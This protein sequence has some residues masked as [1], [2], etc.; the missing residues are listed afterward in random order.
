MDYRNDSRICL[1]E[2]GHARKIQASIAIPDFS[3]AIACV[4]EHFVLSEYESG[5]AVKNRLNGSISISYSIPES[6]I[7]ATILFSKPESC[8]KSLCNCSERSEVVC[9]AEL[10][11]EISE[12]SMENYCHRKVIKAGTI[13]VDERKI[14]SDEEHV[15]SDS[16]HSAFTRILSVEIKNLFLNLPVRQ[17]AILTSKEMQKSQADKICRLMK[18]YALLFPQ[19]KIHL[20]DRSSRNSILRIPEQMS[21]NYISRFKFLLGS[22][23]KTPLSEF[24]SMVEGVE[25]SAFFSSAGEFYS[26]PSESEAV[27]LIFFNG[28]RVLDSI[29][30]ET[31][32]NTFASKITQKFPEARKAKRLPHFL[33][34][35]HAE[36]FENSGMKGE[37]LSKDDLSYPLISVPLNQVRRICELTE[38]A[39]ETIEINETLFSQDDPF[40]HE[41]IGDNFPAARIEKNS[42]AAVRTRKFS[43]PPELDSQRTRPSIPNRVK[44]RPFNFFDS[45]T[46]FSARQNVDAKRARHSDPSTKLSTLYKKWKNSIYIRPDEPL[47]IFSRVVPITNIQKQDLQK[48]QIIGQVDRKFIA[49]RC[50]SLIYVIDQHAA[51][52]R[53][54]LERYLSRLEENPSSIYTY[55]YLENPELLSL[56]YEE[57]QLIQRWNFC[58]A[59]LTPDHFSTVD[60]RGKVKHVA[61]SQTLNILGTELHGKRLSEFIEECLRLSVTVG[62]S[63]HKILGRSRILLGILASKSCRGAIMFGDYLSLEQCT[64]MIENLSGCTFP[65]Q[66]AH[67]RPSIVPLADMSQP[68]PRISISCPENQRSAPLIENLINRRHEISRSEI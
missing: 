56:T 17:N 2:D 25:V 60:I 34:L 57:Y 1:V 61:I 11:G 45:T 44:M 28:F 22:R 40:M 13:V 30:L 59:G 35:L 51:D 9:L 21:A 62:S 15:I 63:L 23:L 6:L 27:Q 24:K 48:M 8:S 49:C 67:G 36:P 29:I 47:K 66:C 31:I 55:V 50:N 38:N 4:L 32:N 39:L 65:F 41:D 33:M 5:E 58:S 16:T 26:W 12:L 37:H 10:L 46:E 14:H 54:R 20:F 19:N 52:E 7:Q 18:I 42:N 64:N 53:I 68:P 3:G 43:P